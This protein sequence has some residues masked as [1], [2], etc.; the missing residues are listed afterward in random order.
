MICR[1]HWLRRSFRIVARTLSNSARVIADMGT[2]GFKKAE[3]R[4]YF[5]IMAAK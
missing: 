3:G 2:G 1:I 4:M 5:I